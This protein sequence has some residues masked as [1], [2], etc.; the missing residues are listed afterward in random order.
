M[1]KEK[2]LGNNLNKASNLME[3]ILK[4]STLK[5]AN[6][7]IDS[8]I[9]QD[10]TPTDTGYPMM[11]LALKG[12]IHGGGISSGIIQFCGVSKSFK[13]SFMLML[14]GAYLREHKDAIFV[15]FDN[16][17]GTRQKYFEQFD[18]PVDRCCHLP[19]ESIEELKFELVKQLDQ[20]T[21]DD[22]IIIGV[23]SLGLAS[24]LK[25]L[26]DATDQKSKQDMS[27]PKSLRSLFRIITPKIALKK[28][29]A[30][31]INHIYSSMDFFPTDIVGGGQGSILASNS[32]F[33]VSKQ[34]LKEGETH[35]GYKFMLKVNKSRDLKDAVVIPF[36][37]KWNGTMS[38]YT[39]MDVI[40]E[41]FGIIEKCKEGKRSAYQYETLSGE[42]IKVL[43]KD[44]DD[45]KDFWEII[46]KET[47][48]VYRIEKM[49]QLGKPSN[50]VLNIEADTTEVPQMVNI[51]EECEDIEE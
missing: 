50:D 31:F 13:S 2:V 6:R 24:S 36:S 34:K 41:N 26:T 15:Y 20:F 32:I 38:K 46:M 16:E 8:Q 28:I 43:E 25:E 3:R 12:K 39:G 51:P 29:P 45:A 1:A 47:D 7:L 9:L 49:Y 37:I 4:N 19:F 21:E 14:V 17:F 44:V 18:I 48:L 23:D 11:N 30:I 5:H 27:R 33:I 42:I 22:K 10:E 35:V 40:A